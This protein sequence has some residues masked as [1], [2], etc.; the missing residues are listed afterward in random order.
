MKVTLSGQLFESKKVR[1]RQRPVGV[2]SPH[3]VRRA[4]ARTEGTLWQRRMRSLAMRLPKGRTHRD[5]S[6][7]PIKRG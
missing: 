2:P 6:G 1:I 7:S 5:R 4:S 3:R